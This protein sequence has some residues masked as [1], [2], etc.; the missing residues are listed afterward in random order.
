[1]STIL[2]T[3]YEPFGEFETNPARQLATALDGTRVAGATLV[4]REL[5]VAFDRARPALVEHI[6]RHD[7]TLVVSLG[8]AAGRPALSLERVGINLR[9]TAGTP[10]NDHRSVLDDPVDV[11]GPDAYFSTLPVREMQ[12]AMREAGV[13]TTLSTSAGTHLCNDILYATRRYVETNDLETRSGFV[14]VPLSHEQAATRETTQP[15]MALETMRRGIE[16]ELKTALGI[17]LE[18]ALEE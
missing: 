1:M 15:S 14:H 17:G 8:L 3:G 11:G 7:P 18:T 16:V 10:D 6:E 4:G 9:D 5:P 13:P 12:T 2:V